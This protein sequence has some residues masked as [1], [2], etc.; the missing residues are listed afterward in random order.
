LRIQEAVYQAGA[1]GFAVGSEAGAGSDADP[2]SA[3]FPAS[4]P[5]LTRSGSVFL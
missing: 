5:E 1:P 2:A 4:L 3:G